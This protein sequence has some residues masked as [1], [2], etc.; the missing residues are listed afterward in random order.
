MENHEIRTTS[1]I[2]AYAALIG[3]LCMIAGAVI[4]GASGADLDKALDTG[5]LANYLVAANDT[6]TLLIAN[7]SIWILG[8]III[9]IAGTMM[10]ELGSEQKL[11]GRI[12]TYN[13]WIGVPLV[14]V[15]YVAWLAIV[16]RLAPMNSPT[17]ATIAE[18]MGWFASRA[19][20]IA[21][22]LVLATGPAL[23]AK[24]G[25]GTWVPGWLVV[26]SYI[27]LIA[28]LLNLIGMYAGGLTTYG[29]LIIPVGMGWMIAASIVLFKKSAKMQ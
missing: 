6:Q 22:I 13:Y 23:I 29:F 12:A 21:T 4:W 17:A 15:A 26:W 2:G 16:V 19:D 28:G 20:W 10:A 9:G 25:K 8:I 1:R 18:V 24:A 7:L 5:E 3:T 14:L 11:I 27:T